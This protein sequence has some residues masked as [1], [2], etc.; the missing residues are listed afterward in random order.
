MVVG[1]VVA[2]PVDPVWELPVLWLWAGVEDSVAVSLPIFWPK[3][4]GAR[5]GPV[6]APIGTRPRRSGRAKVVR[7]LPP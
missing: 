5:P 1:S 4:I 2:E 7:P 3:R 6:P